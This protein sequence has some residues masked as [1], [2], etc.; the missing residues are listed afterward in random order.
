MADIDPDLDSDPGLSGLLNEEVDWRFLGAPTSGS[1]RVADL[2][3]QGWSLLDGDLMLPCAVLKRDMIEHNRRWMRAFLKA[4]GTKISPHGKTTMAP[5]LFERQLADGAWGMTAA[6]PAHVRIYSHFGVER[7]LLANQLVGKR[8]IA[9]VFALLRALPELDFYAL[10]DSVEG[11]EMLASMVG[12]HP[13]GRPLQLLVECGLAGGRTGARSAKEAFAVAR[14]V[15]A[16]DGLALRGVEGFE[17]AIRG[18]RTDAPVDK[19][20]S[21][22]ELMLEVGAV[23]K[24]EG[25]FAPGK[26]LL[27]AGGSAFFDIVAKILAGDTAPKGF[28]VVLRAGCYI[29]HDSG[30]YTDLLA[31]MAGRSGPILPH[32]TLQPALE[33]W[34]AVQSLPEPG[35]AILTLGKR[36]AP[37]DV[38]LPQPVA[39]F[40]AGMTRP[41]ATPK[42]WAVDRL[43]DQHCYMKIDEG[44]DLRLGDLVGFGVSH[45]CGAFDRWP[46]LFEVDRHY[47][48]VGGIRTYF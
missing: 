14:A 19:V 44:A 42:A 30:F 41:Q 32:G 13:I 10:V 12:R 48:V 37:F 28:E 33:V 18:S 15:A 9:E 27:T 6:T 22:M 16:S 8:N 24:D 31:E 29:S 46:L 43:D 45:P 3:A 4:T 1:V 21:L 36:D 40:R 38:R 26:P 23:A 5:Q 39:Q 20:E 34:A 35:L 47:N 17:G 7:I 11:V 25:W 2:G